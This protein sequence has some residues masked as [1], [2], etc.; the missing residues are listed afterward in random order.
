MTKTAIYTPEERIIRNKE[1]GHRWYLAHKEEVNRK[2]KLSSKKRRVENPKK[3]YE[4]MYRSSRK[5]YQTPR[6]I[7]TIIKQNSRVKKR[8]ILISREE[9]LVWYESQPKVCH[10]CGIP[11]NGIRLEIDRL[12]NDLPYQKGNIALACKECNGVKGNIMTEEEMLVV[13]E[14]VMKKRWSKCV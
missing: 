12:N 8:P 10:Y 6:G 9:F 13:G 3:Y 1:N 11:Q 14:T 2:A 5:F 4:S 7:Y